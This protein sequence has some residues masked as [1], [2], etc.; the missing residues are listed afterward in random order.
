MNCLTVRCF[1]VLQ[2]SNKRRAFADQ[3]V[4]S[5]EANSFFASLHLDSL[6]YPLPTNFLHAIPCSA[7]SPSLSLQKRPAW[8]L[9]S[10]CAWNFLVQYNLVN[11]YKR[12]IKCQ[13]PAVERCS[14]DV[15]LILPNRQHRGTWRTAQELSQ[16]FQWSGRGFLWHGVPS[17]DIQQ[18]WCCNITS[19][20]NH[21]T[22]AKHVF[23]GNLRTSPC[24][25]LI[26]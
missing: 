7:L 18:Y 11:H 4:I 17:R 16:Q 13:I 23:S 12:T 6:A 1:L 19:G 5:P 8:G 9:H 10:T 22:F 24:K 14:W 2:N 20:R 21:G 25:W 3:P 26:V 15:P